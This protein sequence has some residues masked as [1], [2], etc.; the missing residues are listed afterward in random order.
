MKSGKFPG[1]REQL[2]LT[3]TKSFYGMKVSKGPVRL[4]FR[5]KYLMVQICETKQSGKR[6]FS[7]LFHTE[8]EKS[9]ETQ[10]V[11]PSYILADGLWA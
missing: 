9:V 1:E 4:S 8:L 2:V 5:K 10:V 11:I 3:L 6:I 7:D